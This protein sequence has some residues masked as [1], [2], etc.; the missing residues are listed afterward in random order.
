MRRFRTCVDRGAVRGGFSIL[1]LLVAVTITVIIVVMLAQATLLS[2]STWLNVQG[3]IERHQS[4]RAILDSMRADLG[5]ALLSLNPTGSSDPAHRDGLQFILNPDLP[6]ELKN[7]SAL[8]WQAPIAPDSK[9]GEVAEV[10]YFVKWDTSDSKN[11]RPNLCRFF[12]GSDNEEAFQIYK[13][14]NQWLTADLVKSVAAA[15]KQSNY[16]GLFAE[17]VVGFWA[18]CMKWDDAKKDM[19]PIDDDVKAQFDS[20]EGFDPKRDPATGR[21]VTKRLPFAVELG[22]VLIDERH[23]SLITASEQTVITRL[24]NEAVSPAEFVKKAQDEPTLKKVVKGMRA[25][26]STIPLKNY[27]ELGF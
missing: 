14:P 12:V 10:G 3:R 27:S 20:R 8:F 16:A 1:E 7:P 22:I 21:T 18:R 17:D 15:D 5:N 13:T 25:Y 4:A 19:I 6:E 24:V 2:S 23:A 26:S 11:P 9:A